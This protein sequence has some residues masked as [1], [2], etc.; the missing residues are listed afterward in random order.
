MTSCGVPT[1]SFLEESK[2]HFKDLPNH[3]HRDF[4][5]GCGQRVV[6]AV[7]DF[8]MQQWEREIKEEKSEILSNKPLC[9]WFAAAN[10]Q[11]PE[12]E[13][14]GFF[15]T[16]S[17]RNI[18]SLGRFLWSNTSL[19]TLDLSNIGLE[20]KEGVFLARAL[21]N[22]GTLLRL[23]LSM[24]KLGPMLCSEMGPAL[25]CNTALQVMNID[26]NPLS[27][28]EEDGNNGIKALAEGLADN[29]T[30]RELSLRNC[31]I[32]AEGGRY[33]SM[34]D[35]RLVSIEIEN[36]HFCLEDVSLLRERLESN[37]KKEESY[38]LAEEAK[39]G[40][41]LTRDVFKTELEMKK[42]EQTREFLEHEKRQREIGRSL[43]IK[44]EA[45][46]KEKAMKEKEIQRRAQVLEE[47]RL[48]AKTK[49]KG[50]AKGKKK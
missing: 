37:L 13:P 38:K 40:V 10:E 25:S 28:G 45:E 26:S 32:N 30:L 17:H 23:N 35:T 6:A 46:A 36:N 47:E 8:E 18:R 43:K 33:L 2:E 1:L 31:N 9:R 29:T 39:R 21:K 42:V 24:N 22:N 15:Q 7:R 48:A 27:R 44:E 20:D 16:C 14:P 41:V 3:D 50:K 19:S 11:P 49:K 4:K 34:A 12:Q 5:S